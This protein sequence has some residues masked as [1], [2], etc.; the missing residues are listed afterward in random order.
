[1]FGADMAERSFTEKE[2]SEIVAYTQI[3]VIC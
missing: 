2:V 3:L 1:M